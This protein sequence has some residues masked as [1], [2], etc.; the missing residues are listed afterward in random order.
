MDLLVLE[1]DDLYYAQPADEVNELKEENTQTVS[2][3]ASVASA[4]TEVDSAA[5][6]EAGAAAA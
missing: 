3:Y 2:N 4:A 6:S 1:S 5:G